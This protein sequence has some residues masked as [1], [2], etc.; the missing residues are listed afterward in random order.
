MALLKPQDRVE[1]PFDWNIS[2]RIVVKDNHRPC[3]PNPVDP[4]PLL[5]KVVNYPVNSHKLL[6]LLYKPNSVH[7]QTATNIKKY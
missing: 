4:T 2:T 7:W 1:I 5:P 6:A 3:I